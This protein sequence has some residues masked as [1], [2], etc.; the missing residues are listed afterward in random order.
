MTD[1]KFCGLTREDDVREAVRLGAAYVGAIMTE[2]PRRVSPQRAFDLFSAIDGERPKSVGV[3]GNESVEDI[4]RASG[5]AGVDVVQLHGNS[6]VDESALSRIRSE[7][8]A[9]VWRVMRVGQDGIIREY[10][11]LPG[12]NGFVMDTSSQ[13]LLGGT[14]RAFPWHRVTDVVRGLRG[15]GKFI[16]AGGLRPENVREAIEVLAPDVVDVSSGVESQPGIKDHARMAA[17]INAVRH[18]S[19]APVQS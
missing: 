2:S 7:I 3:F 17:F 6:I 10:L 16:L 1:V 14:G 15:A 9:E 4:L 12:A 5:T 19:S 13:G 8:G 18:D 11:S